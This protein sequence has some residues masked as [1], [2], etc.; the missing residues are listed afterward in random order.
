MRIVFSLQ[1][2]FTGPRCCIVFFLFVVVVV[3]CG[4]TFV[5]MIANE[6]VNCTDFTGDTQ[7]KL[8][9]DLLK[10]QYTFNLL[11]EHGHFVSFGAIW[12]FG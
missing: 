10:A 12:R 7:I 3:L 5:K 1:I 4:R 9:L 8:A 6:Q 11:S 2:N